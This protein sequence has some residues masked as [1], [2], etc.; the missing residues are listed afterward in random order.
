MLEQLRK[1][2]GSWVARI[3]LGLLIVSFG[4]WGVG[5]FIQ[6]TQDR[7]V[8]KVGD[9]AITAQEFD[10][11][12]RRELQVWQQRLGLVIDNERAR[13]LGLPDTTLQTMVQRALI[14]QEVARLGLAIGNDALVR[15]IR[16]NPA[17]RNSF[18]QFD[19]FVFE[20]VLA[21]NGWGERAYVELLR[22]DTLRDHLLG[23]IEPAGLPAPSVLTDRVLA[24]REERRI[25]EVL[26]IAPQMLGQIA[27]PDQA[28]L[29]QF[30][31]DNAARFTVPELRRLS[32]VLVT[33]DALSSQVSVTDQEVQEEYEARRAE[34][35]QPERRQVEQ[36]V[37]PAEAE[38]KA[39]ALRL[40]KG[41]DFAAVA[42]ATRNLEAKDIALGSLLKTD[43]PG[44]VGEAAFALEKGK[45][46]D[47]VQSPFG[48]HLVRVVDIAPGRT[49][50]LAEVRDQ[51]R[52]AVA[53]RKAGD[54]TFRVANLLEDEVA[55]GGTL[56]Q[57]ADK[58]NLKVA[59]IEAVDA[60]GRDA[61]GQ[62]VALPALANFL[63]T[64][65]QS[66]QG[67]EPRLTEANDGQAFMVRVDEVVPAA[68]RPFAEVRA[69][70]LEA[71]RQ[72][73]GD[74]RTAARA[75]EIADRLKEGGNFAALARGIGGEVRT[76]QPFTRT[77]QG[78]ETGTSA[79]LVAA[80]FAAKKGDVVTA[81]AGA[82]QGHLVARVADVRAYDPASDAAGRERLSRQLAEGIVQDLGQQYRAA[83]ESRYGVRINRQLLETL[84]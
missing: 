59:R 29:E 75:R 5:D 21:Q 78:A 47:P 65:F 81:S 77:G 36:I 67:A 2:A 50:P 30:H 66:A 17:F 14:D 57:A 41:E 43:L 12:Y 71:W 68:L 11:Q 26:T 15:E 64:A 38:A 4:I 7:D 10:Q 33:P 31:K 76:T 9:T 1:G 37:Y 40:A 49:R 32:Y 82:G 24:Y 46:S 54:Q 27:E 79:R 16:N 52:Q 6:G 35:E 20:Q 39:A 62:P 56:E 18:G 42:K 84:F 58:L 55:G 61:K 19:R 60:Q 69:E 74:E 45:V 73:Q 53:L 22:R 83:L 8:A 80:V 25:A 48:W 44:P 23:A 34:F 63:P 28:T 13:Q 51:M 3:L 72:S 70:V